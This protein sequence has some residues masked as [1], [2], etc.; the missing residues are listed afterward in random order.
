[1]EKPFNKSTLRR[2]SLNI[3]EF[4]F[5]DWESIPDFLKPTQNEVDSI[6]RS[7]LLDYGNKPIV[8]SFLI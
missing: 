7:I 4:V 8:S 1:M 2:N 3:F 5:L 6:L